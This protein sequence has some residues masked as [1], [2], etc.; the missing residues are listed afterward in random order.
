MSAQIIQFREGKA[1]VLANRKAALVR[2]LAAELEHWAA[3]SSRLYMAGY[4]EAMGWASASDI[5]L[6]LEALEGK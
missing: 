1:L 3:G 2:D 5:Q 6:A 4:Y